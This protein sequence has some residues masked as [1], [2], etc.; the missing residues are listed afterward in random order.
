MNLGKEVI[1]LIK[2]INTEPKVLGSYDNGNYK[3]TIYENGTKIRETFDENATEFLPLKP[4]CMDVKITNC[5]DRN[6][7]MCHEDSKI[8]GEHGEI[9]A[10]KF[11]ETL[12]PYTEIALGG[13]NP[14]SHPDLVALLL[15]LKGLNLIPNMTVNQYHFM[16]NKEFI[17]FLCNEKLIYGLGVS[18][19]DANDAFIKEIQKFPNAVIHI[20]NG[21]VTMDELQKLANKNLKVLILGYKTF[22][23]GKEYYQ[24]SGN[25]VEKL[26]QMLF[27]YLPEMIKQFNVV[28]FDNLALE[29][30][31]VRRLLTDD[32]WNTFYMGND[33]NYTMY[34][35]LVKQNFALS[36]V[37]TERFELLDNI[38]PMFAKVRE[39]SGLKK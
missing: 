28:S 25:K 35:D 32:E 30:L 31:N 5:C 38:Q 10:A 23:R 27:N 7:K 19:T 6:C 39:V 12:H 18:L 34:I 17:R 16:E 20:I 1:F 15:K 21:I 36:S 3:V 37:S 24:N 14:L 33:G 22:R 2:I 8:D 4:E 29:Q 13:G 9:L 11:W 26:K